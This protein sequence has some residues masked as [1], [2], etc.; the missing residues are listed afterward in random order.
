MLF[1]SMNYLAY[2]WIERGE[3]INNK[4]DF[5]DFISLSL[6]DETIKSI[7]ETYSIKFELDDDDVGMEL[8]AY[9]IASSV[10]AVNISEVIEEVC[11]NERR[12]D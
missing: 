5:S 6:S 12:T 11:S 7:I 3:N 8:E 2:S 1:R 9:A 4:E 10:Q